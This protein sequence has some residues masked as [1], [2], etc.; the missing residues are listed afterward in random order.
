MIIWILGGALT[1]AVL[2]IG[3]YI[4]NNMTYFERDMPAATRD[5]IR[6]TAIVQA[7]ENRVSS[8]MLPPVCRMKAEP[9]PCWIPILTICE[10]RSG[11]ARCVCA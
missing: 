1:L 2:G 3:G 8:N 6:T 11:K 7:P 9:A 5:E 4:F 10:S